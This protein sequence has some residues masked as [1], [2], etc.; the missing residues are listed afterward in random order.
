MAPR[1][2]VLRLCLRPLGTLTLALAGLVV[3]PVWTGATAGADAPIEP[4]ANIESAARHVALSQ[5]GSGDPA[6]VEVQAIDPRLR[7]PACTSGLSGALAPGMRTAARMTVEV[8]CLEPRWRI[9]LGVTLH[10]VEKV[11]VTTRPLT[12]L[13][14]LGPEDLATVE[15]EVS[16]LPGGFYRSPDALYGKLTSRVIG[17]GEVLT[18]AL[19]QI[20]PLVRRGQQVTVVAR[21]GAL[22]VR[23]SGTALA[24]AGL[25]QRI[26]VQTGSGN[27]RPVEGVVRAADLVEIA[28]P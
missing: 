7:Y 8:H 9:Y 17:A 12:R 19:V 22:E 6:T 10:T 13:A 14:P 20:P 25:E 18:P 27:G 3:A 15:R 2:A 24:D 26:Q 11:V 4:V 1:H 23:Q 21:R 28:V 16:L 5:I